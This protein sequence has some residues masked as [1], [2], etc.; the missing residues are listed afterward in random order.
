VSSPS[1]N[2]GLRPDLA[3]A[4][5]DWWA[6]E[7]G[8]SRERFQRPTIKRHVPETRRVNAGDDYHGCLAISVPKSRELYWLVEGIVDAL[9]ELG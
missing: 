2:A 4:G 3:G 7:L 8:V 1:K 6:C 9:T 5:A